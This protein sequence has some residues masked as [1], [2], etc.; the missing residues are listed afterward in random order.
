[1][2]RLLGGL[3]GLLALACGGGGNADYNEHIS[4]DGGFDLPAPAP[5]ATPAVAVAPGSWPSTIRGV[6][7]M[8]FDC[9]CPEWTDVDACVAQLGPDGIIEGYGGAACMVGMSCGTMCGGGGVQCIK[10]AYA[11]AA[12][13]SNQT[14]E[15]GR[16]QREAWPTGGPCSS[17]QTEVRDQYGNFLRCE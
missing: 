7:Q 17:T 11:A 9:G 14:Y 16:H 6:C 12:A 13:I 15:M 2:R 1:M 10:D 8:T 5:I 3:T 4:S